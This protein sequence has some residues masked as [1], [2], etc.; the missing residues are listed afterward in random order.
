MLDYFETGKEIIDAAR[1]R[2][3]MAL[4][5]MDVALSVLVPQPAPEGLNTVATDTQYVFFN[6]RWLAD[7]YRRSG[8]FVNRMYLHMVL[9]CILRHPFKARG[10]EG[11]EAMLWDIACDAAVESIMDGLSYPCLDEGTVPAKQHFLMRCEKEMPVLTA[12]GIYRYL[13][14]A[15]LEEDE[16]K[17]LWRAFR[18]DDH[19]LWAGAD[20]EKSPGAGEQEQM[21]SEVADKTMSGMETVFT[22]SGAPGAGLLQQL[23]VAARSDVDY[24]EFLRR[25]AAPREVMKVDGDAFDYVYY[26]YGLR[27]FGNM[28]L[29]EPP[30]TKEERRIEEF[31]IA[32]D[33]SM[34]TN[35]VLVRE[36][37]ACTYGILKSF[38]TFTERFNIHIIQCDDRVRSDV[39]IERLSEL[40]SYMEH[41]ELSG[42]ST[43]DFR[44]VFEHV[45]KLQASGELNGLRGLVYF[46]DGMGRF[47]KDRPKYDTAFVML[48]EP[49]DFIRIPAWA[50]KLVIDT[51]D[52]ER[53]VAQTD[54]D[55][56]RELWDELPRS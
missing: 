18:T 34:S 12:E 1:S 8:I 20:D 36:F 32:V 48:Q 19:G 23:K 33:T 28:P 3:Y 17:A 39:K 11:G 22:D 43:T 6:G 13:K 31:V 35:G 41:F 55:E 16:L 21:W 50:I 4:P 5:Y 2:L 30:E 27:L 37:L 46:T 54:D 15:Q 10:Y 45:A 26:T 44:P 49:P 52:M 47:P 7:R 38:E 56:L 9:H 53:A 40:R 25:F 24:R 14:R 51:P 29:V 42:G